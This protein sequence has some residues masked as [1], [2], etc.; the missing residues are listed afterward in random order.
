MSSAL[1]VRSNSYIG[2]MK[3]QRAW[4]DE[5]LRHAVASSETYRQVERLLGLATGSLNYLKKQIERLGLD[6]SHFDRHPKQKLCG[7]DEL[8]DLVR[9]SQTRSEVLGKLGLELRGA[10]FA[11]LK[12]RIFALGIDTSHFARPTV[13]PGQ[14]RK[15]R[16]SDDELRHAVATSASYAQTIRALGLIA[17]G[18]NYDQVQKRIR[19]LALDTKHFTGG[20]WNVGMHYQ[21]AP[22][23]PLERV[24][25]AGR[26]TGSHLL[27]KRLIAAGMK[28]PRC[29]LC[30]WEERAADGRVPVELDH[31]NGDRFDNRLDNLRILC[32]NCHSLQ[33]TH[34][35]LNQ[36]R[37]KSRAARASEP[38]TIMSGPRRTRTDTWGILSPLPRPIGLEG[39]I[40]DLS[41]LRHTSRDASPR[42]RAYATP[43]PVSHVP[44]R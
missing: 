33:P 17:A 24:L 40:T 23:V 42:S 1:D 21:P 43:A 18:G 38:R 16:W 22:A 14:N 27:K 25:V 41:S 34:R 8:R 37:A 31:M 26:A 15:R 35:G 30:G 2:T 7:D 6:T 9:T 36:A 11:K 28:E 5:E 32:P 29:E 12:R 10:H 13:G 20:G 19:E 3:K 39:R 44:C 4:S